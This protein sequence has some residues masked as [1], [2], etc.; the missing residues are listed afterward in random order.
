MELQP[1]EL[2]ELILFARNV[3]TILLKAFKA[4]A[5]NWSVQDNEAAGQTIAHLHMH[6]VLRFKNDLPDPGDWYPKVKNNFSEIL[7]S[8][9]RQK[10]TTEEMQKIVETLRKESKIRGF[11]Y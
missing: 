9:S 7:D 1:E 8:V 6:I 10:L 5:F 2:N 11:W 3:T 4:E